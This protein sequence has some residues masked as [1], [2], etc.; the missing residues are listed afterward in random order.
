VSA[1]K[2]ATKEV[3]GHLEIIAVACKAVQRIF[4]MHI[5]PGGT[6]HAAVFEISA[7]ARVL[8]GRKLDIDEKEAIAFMLK[9]RVEELHGE[10]SY[11]PKKGEAA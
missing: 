9:E 2:W 6:P 3:R 10:L 8:D 11:R 7:L 1:P 4:D 5:Q